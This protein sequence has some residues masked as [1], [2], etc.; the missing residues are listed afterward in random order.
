M[1]KLVAPNTLY[2]QSW[3]A[4]SREFDGAWRDGSGGE[5][6]FEQMED[7]AQ[8][9]EY[10]Q[11]LIK[12]AQP[13]APRPDGHVPCTFLWLVENGTVLGFL[14]IRHVLNDFLLTEGG[15]IGYSVRPSARRQ[16]H[17]TRALQEALPIARELGIMDV[18]VTCNEAN[19]GSRATIEGNGG[20][21]ED[22][23]NG[24]RRYWI[25]TLN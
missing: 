7:V 4:A 22:S 20:R 10:V 14:A 16:G 15:H 6:S 5:V 19:I 24:A 23:R 1:A 18:L 12:Q 21:Y 9:Q 13:D 3:L 11:G 25:P 8:F 2:H 17:A